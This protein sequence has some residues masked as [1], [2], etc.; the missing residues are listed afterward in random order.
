VSDIITLH[1]KGCQLV[2][3]MREGGPVAFVHHDGRELARIEGVCIIECA[4]KAQRRIDQMRPGEVR[5]SLGEAP[6]A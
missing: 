4:N 1:Y 3:G 6:A 2:A 5:P